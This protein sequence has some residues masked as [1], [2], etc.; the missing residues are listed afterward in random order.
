MGETPAP[1]YSLPLLPHGDALA[2]AHGSNVALWAEIGVILITVIVTDR[3][4]LRPSAFGFA[5]SAQKVVLVPSESKVAET[6]L[7][8]GQR[9]VGSEPWLTSRSST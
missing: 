2:S 7:G 1:Q 6:G 3:C 8:T 5:H 4:S 9:R